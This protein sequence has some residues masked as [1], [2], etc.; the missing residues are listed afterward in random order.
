MNIRSGAE[1]AT[2]ATAEVLAMAG[3]S[4]LSD[5][6]SASMGSAGTAAAAVRRGVSG[7]GLWDSAQAQVAAAEFKAGALYRGNIYTVQDNR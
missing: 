4:R 1:D 2:A 7:M 3:I 5:A 6:L